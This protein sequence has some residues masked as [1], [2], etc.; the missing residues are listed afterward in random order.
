LLLPIKIRD[1]AHL[2][3]ETLFSFQRSTSFDKLLLI[4]LN[5]YIVA[6]LT[7]SVKNFFE[8]ILNKNSKPFIK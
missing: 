3:I 8:N 4:K 2:L 5:Y 7:L 1:P 6:I